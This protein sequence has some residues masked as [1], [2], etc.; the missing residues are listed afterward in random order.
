LAA[1]LVY[2]MHEAMRS[3][4]QN[5]LDNW[6]VTFY[7]AMEVARENLKQLPQK[8]IGPE[9]GSGVYLSAN[10]DNYDASRLL[11]VDLIHQFNLD[12]D[13]IAM[14]PTRDTLVV[15][16]SDD[17]DAL[18]GLLALAKDAV[19]KQPGFVST[20]AVRLDGDEWEP[21]LPAS[22][23]PLYNDFK[24]MQVES[25]VAEYTAQKEL[26]DK[27]HEARGEDLFAATY[28]AVQNEQTGQLSTYSVWAGDITSWLP[29]TDMLAFMRHPGDKPRMF[30]WDRVV[31]VAGHLMEPLD[32]HPPRFKVSE[33]PSEEQFAA[34]GEE[35][36]L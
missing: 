33:F 28:K 10:G 15:A 36:V 22:S 29:Q 3:I 31:E 34:M 9:E 21:W 8:F 23:R 24:L 13:P 35:I 30:Q 32:M 17:L 1:G 12:G 20:V 26:L 18:K 7:E 4:V 25:L 27:L 11:L 14:A 19:E 6:G 5:D 2:D 16:G